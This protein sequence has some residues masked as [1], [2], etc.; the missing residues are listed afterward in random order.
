MDNQWENAEA[1]SSFASVGSA[2]RIVT[3]EV[4]LSLRVTKPHIRDPCYDWKL[5]K[6]DK[7]LQQQFTIEQIS[8]VGF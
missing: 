6:Y 5:L 2:C 7:A 3:I 4:K 8:N 1:Y